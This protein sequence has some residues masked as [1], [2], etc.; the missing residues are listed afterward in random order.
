[1][2][3]ALLKK[4]MNENPIHWGNVDLLDTSKHRG[5]YIN[6]LKRADMGDYQPLLSKFLEGT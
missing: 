4:A 1:M 5:E 2:T 3:D 6:A